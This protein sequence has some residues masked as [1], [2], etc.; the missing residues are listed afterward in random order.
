MSPMTYTEVNG[1]I[2]R[3]NQCSQNIPN[4]M[5]ICKICSKVKH[6]KKEMKKKEENKY[7]V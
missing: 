2:Y 7:F 1:A 4:K 5:T 3:G 6:Y